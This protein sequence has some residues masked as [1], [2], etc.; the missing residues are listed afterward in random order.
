MCGPDA[1]ELGRMG[2]VLWARQYE[3]VLAESATAAVSV[4]KTS[5][6]GC[7]MA[8]GLHGVAWAEDALSA[9]LDA[10]P[11]MPTL[12]IAPARCGTVSRAAVTVEAGD[13]ARVMEALRVLCM[14]RRG[15]KTAGC[16]VFR[17]E[18]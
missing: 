11:G 3:A 4:L 8:L 5:E 17:D 18:H 15:P 1:D 2:Y 13:M 6:I 14:R 9:M 16:A 7:V 12:L 10:V